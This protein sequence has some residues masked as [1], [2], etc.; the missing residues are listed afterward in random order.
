MYC[1]LER[2]IDFKTGPFPNLENLLLCFPFYQN[3]GKRLLKSPKIY[4]S[5]TALAPY[6]MGLHEREAALKGPGFGP[7]W[8]HGR[9]GRLEAAEVI[10]GATGRFPLKKGIDHFNW[11]NILGA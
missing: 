11:K 2:P 6:L 4:F 7:S 9:Y 5:D 1:R 8:D 10:T 3:L